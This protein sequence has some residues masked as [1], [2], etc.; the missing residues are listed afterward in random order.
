MSAAQINTQSIKAL[1]VVLT[2]PVIWVAHFFALYA[3]E[4]FLCSGAASPAAAAI[5]PLGLTLTAIALAVLSIFLSWQGLQ[6]LR[7]R[8]GAPMHLHSYRRISI[9][10][11]A[12]ALLAVAWSAL[13]V[14]LLPA[15]MPG[16]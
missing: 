5:R 10:L 1:G 16:A 12:M 9:G 3:A 2:G 15:C 6:S 7:N 4:G 11:A 13:P 14:I 8:Q